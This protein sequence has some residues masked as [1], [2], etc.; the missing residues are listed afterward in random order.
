MRTVQDYFISSFGAGRNGRNND[1]EAFAKAFAEIE[2]RGGGRLVVG[3]GTYLTGPWNLP[4]GLELVLERGALV[5]FSTDFRLYPPVKTRWE[6]VE[7]WAHHPLIMADSKKDIHIHGGGTLDGQ[8]KA[9]WDAYRAIRSS[10]RQA[11]ETELELELAELNKDYMSQASGGGG[12]ETQF[13]RPPLFQC[14]NCEGISLENLRLQ[15]SPFWSTHAVYSQNL[16]FRGLLIENPADAPNTDGLDIDSCSGVL[17]EGCEFNVGDDCLA[18]KA[19]SGSDGI[20]VGRPTEDVSV[21]N[22]RMNSGHGGIVIGSE[23][24]G[25][26]RRIRVSDCTFTGT[27][28]GIRI[29][30]RRGRGGNIEDLV[31]ENIEMDGGYCPIAVNSFYRCGADPQDPVLFSTDPQELDPATPRISG[32]S[33]RGIRARNYRS[34]AVFIA[35]LPESPIRGL[36]LLHCSFKIAARE[37]LLPTSE[38]A[39][40]AGLAERDERGLRLEFVDQPRIEALELP[41]L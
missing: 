37:E 10:G 27:D 34:V 38:A 18:L 2:A 21:R 24:A 14:I 8:G 4:S 28:R 7:C 5:R 41:G 35:G 26:I 40:Y 22:C 6:G 32:L 19:G 23:T 3:P 13:L 29:K 31:F 9:W 25:G 17:V 36:E 1:S 11:P 12:R 30:T 20:R 39:M 16:I 15:N 33:F